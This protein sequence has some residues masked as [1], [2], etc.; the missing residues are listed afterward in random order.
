[1]EENEQGIK[2]ENPQKKP[3]KMVVFFLGVA[4]LVFFG[5]FLLWRFLQKPAMGTVY[6]REASYQKVPDTNDEVQ[7]YQGSL[8]SFSC[9][10]KY[11]EK[12]DDKLK[13]GPIQESILLSNP[14]IEGKKI[15]IIVANRQSSDLKSDPS[16]QMREGTPGVYQKKNVDFSGQHA[17]IFEKKNS[18]FEETAF[19]YHAPYIVSISLTSLFRVDG[20]EDE[21]SHLLRTIRWE[22]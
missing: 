16:F 6:L 2:N 5:V 3:R 14:R 21:L 12:T 10:A 17:V 22:S 9:L 18:V 13:D 15:T 4:G 8:F 20:L 1:M 7:T 11:T 19:F